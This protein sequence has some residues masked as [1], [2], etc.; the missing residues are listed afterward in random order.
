[1]G[2]KHPDQ[3]SPD[4]LVALHTLQDNL[5]VIRFWIGN[6]IGVPSDV[7]KFQFQGDRLTG[8]WSSFS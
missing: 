3:P 2:T 8:T 1:M 6:Q 7:L 4:S 5:N